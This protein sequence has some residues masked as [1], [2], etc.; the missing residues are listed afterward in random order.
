MNVQYLKA[1]RLAISRSV[2]TWGRKNFI[3]YP[4]RGTD[5]IWMALV[6]EIMLQRTRV[7]VVEPTWKEFIRNYPT[8]SMAATSDPDEFTRILKPLG[9]KWRSDNMREVLQRLNACQCFPRTKK[10]LMALPGV[11]EYIASACLSLHQ[12]IRATIVDANVVRWI[13]RMAGQEYHPET[14][15]KR[16]LIEAAENL[17]PKLVFKDYNYGLL[18]LTMTV[19][20]AKPRCGKCPLSTHCFYYQNL[21]THG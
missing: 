9:L 17:T 1:K 11:G 5:A 7:S 3:N 6:A 14:R 12:N 10:D 15:R 13:C 21:P 19:C 18:D 2:L 16:W 20:T 8:L 4:W